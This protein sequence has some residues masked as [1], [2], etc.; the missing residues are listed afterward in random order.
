M[1]MYL[2]L[3]F[4]VLDGVRGLDLEGD[5]LASK[6]LDKDLHPTT[7]PKDEVEGRFLLDVVVRESTAILQL[8]PSEDQP[9]LVRWDSLLVLI[10]LEEP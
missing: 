7:K 4:H 6:R 8:L 3:G 1:T 10:R 5:S 2:N 9:L